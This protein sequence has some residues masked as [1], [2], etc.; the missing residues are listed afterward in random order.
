MLYVLLLAALLPLLPLGGGLSARFPAGW[1]GLAERPPLAWRSY[2]A[3]VQGMPLDQQTMVAA[4]DALTNRS[5]SV[6]GVPTSLWDLGYRTAG[7]DG[8]WEL[9]VNKSMHDGQGH[10]LIDASKFPSMK[11]LTDYAHARNVSMG[12]Y[13][14]VC[15]CP[16]QQQR[17]R[18][19]EG[20]VQALYSLGFDGAKYDGC[21]QMKNST[22]VAS[23]MNAT[24]KS[25]LIENCHWGICTDSDD[26]SCPTP[27][28]DWCKTPHIAA[29][30]VAFF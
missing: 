26:S 23:L 15:G 7:I 3:Q 30:W 5:R 8:G 13:Q 17:M 16:P 20:D 21:G 14:N 1:N 6:G 27:N 28:R 10:P 18:D 25:F 24:G 11:G 12:W 2:N 19:Y 29:I 22:L 4:I 9:C